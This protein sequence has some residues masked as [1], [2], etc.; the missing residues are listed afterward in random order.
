MERGR[1]ELK[2][3]KVINTTNLCVELN[4]ATLVSLVLLAALRL[5]AH[6]IAQTVASEPA[7]AA[8]VLALE[9]DRTMQRMKYL[10]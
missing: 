8:A 4:F 6:Q 3:T 5:D 1:C 10:A 9:A 7:F 2:K